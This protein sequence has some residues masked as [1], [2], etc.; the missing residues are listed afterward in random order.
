[1]DNIS[2]KLQDGMLTTCSLIWNKDKQDFEF[3]DS[4]QMAKCC[5]KS[6][7]K[8]VEFCYK[9]CGKYKNRDNIERCFLTCNKQRQLCMDNCIINVPHVGK[10]NNYIKCATEKGCMGLNEFPDIDCVK[11]NRSYIFKCCRKSCIPRKNLDCQK[12]CEFL[13]KVTINPSQLGIPRIST[14]KLQDMISE[15]IKDKN[16]N[17]K[18]KIKFP[19]YTLFI[20]L[21]LLIILINMRL[22]Y[23]FKKEN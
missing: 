19:I 8:P 2:K 9:N 21:C 22:I 3:T 23:Y 7:V 20:I 10:G 16:K 4:T 15:Q 17:V 14:E 13:E 18:R 12:H 6:C 1:M 5:I 11:K